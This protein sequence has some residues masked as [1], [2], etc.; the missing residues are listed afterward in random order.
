MASYNYPA[1]NI[2]EHLVVHVRVT[3]LRV[4]WAR[5]WLAR[6]LLV[7]AAWVAGCGLVVDLQE[8]ARRG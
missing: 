6:R 4:F 3:G 7:L 1:R 2:G 8:E 5:W